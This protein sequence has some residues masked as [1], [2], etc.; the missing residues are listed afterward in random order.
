MRCRGYESG[1]G[2]CTIALYP[3]SSSHPMS[4][5]PR[6]SILFAG[7]A[8]AF[9]ACAQTPPLIKLVVPYPPGGSVDVMARLLQQPLQEQFR[10]ILR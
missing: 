10:L 1:T 9:S 2:S 5:L 6:R 3:L 7:L 4:Y 8:A